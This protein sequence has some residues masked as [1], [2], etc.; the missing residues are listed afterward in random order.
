MLL[1]RLFSSLDTPTTY[2]DRNY[3]YTISL[4]HD[5]ENHT[6]FLLSFSNICFYNYLRNG[7]VF[8]TNLAVNKSFLS[9]MILQNS[10]CMRY[11]LKD[12]RINI[13]LSH[14]NN[15]LALQEKINIHE[16]RNFFHTGHLFP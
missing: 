1:I 10:I 15:K 16:R 5:Y 14:F 3:F 8:L 4:S 6:D 9:V 11:V 2:V 7:N 12:N 13:A